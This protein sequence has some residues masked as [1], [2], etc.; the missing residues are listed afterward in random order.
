MKTEEQAILATREESIEHSDSFTNGG[1]D[2]LQ[3]GNDPDIRPIVAKLPERY[4]RGEFHPHIHFTIRT[5]GCSGGLPC[6]G[7]FANADQLN[8]GYLRSL[9]RAGADNCQLPMLVKAVHIVEDEQGMVRTLPLGDSIVWLQRLDDCAGCIT[10]SLY[11]S[12][13]Q[14]KFVGSRRPRGEDWKLDGA[15]VIG[16]LSRFSQKFPNQ[17]VKRSAAMME[18]LANEHRESGRDVLVTPELLEFL[19]ILEIAID[20]FA[21]TP[22]I[23][24]P[25]KFDVKVLDILIGPFESFSYPF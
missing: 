17:V 1:L 8:K 25:I 21:V 10:D 13:E 16:D 22:F 24:K 4:E 18:N 6:C 5:D 14:G 7:V 23:Q 15:R 3:A 9:L 2:A 11:F 12:V 19:D 20:D